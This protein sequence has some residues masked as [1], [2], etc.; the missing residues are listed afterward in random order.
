VAVVCRAY[1]IALRV[2]P[3]RIRGN[4][5]AQMLAVFV[6]LARE[7]HATAGWRGSLRALGSE[8]P[9]LVRLATE[10]HRSEWRRLRDHRADVRAGTHGESAIPLS[11]RSSSMIDAIRSDIRTA[12]R[13]LA[14]NPGLTLVATIS[15]ALGIGA[16]TAIFSVLNGVLF[17]PLGYPDA[18]E[19]VAIGEG[20]EGAPPTTL[21][22]TS[23][24]SFHDWEAG[25][26]AFTEMAA[27]AATQNVLLGRGEPE[28]IQGV[29]TVGGLFELL[30]VPAAIGRTYGVAEEDPGAEAVVVLSHAMWTGVFGGDSGVVG[31]TINLGGRPRRVIGVMPA[32]FRFVSG[33]SLY[34]MPAQYTPEFRANRD[35]YFLGVI[36]RLRPGMTVEEA[37]TD[38]EMVAARLRADWSQYNTRLQLNV[39]SFQAM[40]VTGTQRSL[41]LLMG[42][43]VLV[44]L[45]ACANI[46]NLLLAKGAG[47][48]REIA[49]R[50]ALGASRW[51]I[52]RQLI[53]ESVVLGLTGGLA[54]LLLGRAMLGLLLRQQA[55]GLP[56]MEDITL[57]GRVLAFTVAVAVVAGI[58]FGIVPS[59]RLAS[60]RATDAL[61]SGT[62][63][64]G[65]DRWARRSLVVAEL[66]LAV[67]LLAGAGL[68]LRSFA[69]VQRVDPGLAT[70]HL[71]TFSVA[72]RG[73][74]A[75]FFEQ[76]VERIASLPGVRSVAIVSQLPGTGRGGGAWFNILDR[77]TPAGE[78]PPGEAYRIISPGYFETAGIPLREGRQL[79]DRD[80]LE[81]SPSVIVN[82][83]LA[84]KYWPGGDA[85]GQEI[86]LGAPDN[87][88]IPRATIVGIAG[89]TKD[90]GL[91]ADPLPMV[92]IPLAMV[93][94]A[95]SFTYMIRTTGDPGS[96]VGAARSEIRALEPNAPVR[97]VQ[98]MEDV[99][100]E[101]LAPARWSMTLLSVFAAVAL[102]LA[103][104]GVFGVLSFTV[105]QRTRELGI[106]IALGAAPAAVRR[107]VVR[108]A[109]ALT[110]AG[111]IIGLGAAAVA[112]RAMS[113]ML[114]GVTGTDT[115]TYL[116]VALVLIGVALLASFLPARR[117][118]QVSPLVALQSE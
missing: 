101:S 25:A 42:A 28:L 44:L 63:A 93:P 70:D 29:N 115:L 117:A 39:M 47:R 21:N 104:V 3:A 58:A 81:S 53:T 54:G 18:G 80:R 37:R 36:G 23:P 78:T 6:D 9:G 95:S 90:A 111:V 97:N 57:D 114:F 30:R 50:Q 62:R 64:A 38:L 27:Y 71:L 14:R 89:D 34:W 118:T 85:V 67:V 61:R 72:L 76:S 2:L 99:L 73:G 32:G 31:T 88:V 51:R 103:C 20:R 48:R 33:R 16:N 52:T 60:S 7:A 13:S 45:V 66:A 41:Y 74:P 82:E 98:T 79:T 116:G 49:V 43:V 59:L 10:E 86:Y 110:V 68:L 96:L 40:L 92:F 5:G 1:R 15:L 84:R 8:L 107:L 94:W 102:I 69:L 75:G 105:A 55:I 19:L 87:R 113:A 17:K 24:A 22:S 12:V 91:A 26:R 11:H 112:T 56:R 35:Q 109:L 100:A 106:M 108:E 46:G 83:T 4:Y 65:G 77:P